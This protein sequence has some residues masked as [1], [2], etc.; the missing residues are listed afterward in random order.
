MKYPFE[1]TYQEILAAPEMIAVFD[2]I[3]LGAAVPAPPVL[4][5]QAVHD[6]LIDVN[7]ID[8]LAEAYRRAA[9]ESRITVT[10]STSTC[11]CTRCRHR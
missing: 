2:E 4:L 3:K 10:R 7:D 1:A 8:V 5:V 9:R 6:Y 11:S